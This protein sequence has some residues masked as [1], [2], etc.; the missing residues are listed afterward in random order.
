MTDKQNEWTVH[1]CVWC[2]HKCFGN[3]NWVP[4]NLFSLFFPCFDLDQLKRYTW[5]IEYAQTTSTCSQRQTFHKCNPFT[6]KKTRGK[7][8]Y[9]NSIY[10]IVVLIKTK[11]VLFLS[12][13][14][15][16]LLQFTFNS[17]P[18]LSRSHFF[19]RRFFFYALLFLM[20]FLPRSI[21]LY[22]SEAVIL[23]IASSWV[24]LVKHEM[25]D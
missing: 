3:F 20:R 16:L 5:R 15:L 22:A 25:E 9:K 13:S 19:G 21:F 6:K 14:I 23:K 2:V 8:V 4:V 10:A 12:P 11:I 18:M 1:I 24:H 17:I 7:C